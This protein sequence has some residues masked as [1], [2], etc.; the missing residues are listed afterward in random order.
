MHPSL[1]HRSRVELKLQRPWR[2]RSVLSLPRREVKCLPSNNSTDCAKSRP[3][4]SII[5]F[6]SL[7]GA[8]LIDKWDG[9]GKRGAQPQFRPT[10]NLSASLFHSLS[11]EQ[12]RRPLTRWPLLPINPLANRNGLIALR[13]GARSSAENLIASLAER[14]NPASESKNPRLGAFGDPHVHAVK[15]PI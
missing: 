14:S 11:Q 4:P 12:T 3:N 6:A 13:A 1:S 15:R 8:I 5:D 7:H 2:R 9:D 10:I